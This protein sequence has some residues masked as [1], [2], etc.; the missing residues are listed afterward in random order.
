MMLGQ[1]IKTTKS[2]DP[3]KLKDGLNSVKNYH[4]LQGTVSFSKQNHATITEK[5][6]TLVQYNAAK[7]AWVPIKK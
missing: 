7:N 6:L 1:V 2:T 3:N 4:G 5:Q